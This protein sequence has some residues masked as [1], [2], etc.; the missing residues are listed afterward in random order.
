MHKRGSTCRCSQVEI[1]RSLLISKDFQ[2]NNEQGTRVC[3][4]MKCM[5]SLEGENR[6]SLSKALKLGVKTTKR[7]TNFPLMN[8]CRSL[9]MIHCTESY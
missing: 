6:P 9:C 2:N 4:T 7:A 1:K 5:E 3:F 8:L